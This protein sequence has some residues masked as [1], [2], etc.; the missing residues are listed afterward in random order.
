MP[1]G[2][3][4]DLSEALGEPTTPGA[5]GKPDEWDLQK[6]AAEKRKLEPTVDDRIDNAIR[7]RTSAQMKRLKFVVSPDYAKLLSAAKRR[8]QSIESL[9]AHDPDLRSMLL[10]AKKERN[11]NLLQLCKGLEIDKVPGDKTIGIIWRSIET[12]L[13]GDDGR[14]VWLKIAEILPGLRRSR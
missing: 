5:E 14:N 6:V 10:D 9:A 1:E 12:Q 3:R 13:A 2:D 4:V 8:G 7:A 11:A